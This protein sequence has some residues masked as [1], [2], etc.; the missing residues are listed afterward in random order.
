MDHVDA[1][2]VGQGLAGTALAWQLL[3]RGRSVLVIDREPPVT[4]S[5]IAAGLL[6]P[7]TGKRLAV[8]DRWHE[9]F[10]VAAAFYRAIEAELGVRLFHA[11]PCVRLFAY[12]IELKQYAKGQAEFAGLAGEP[13]PP[14]NSD[15]FHAPRGGFQ[16]PT[17]ARLDT[18]TYLDAS[19]DHF[20][21]RGT[22]FRFD[23]DPLTDIVPSSDAVTIPKLGVS[24]S[25]LVFCQGFTGTANPYFQDAAFEAAKGEI[26]TLRVPGLGETRVM[27]RGVWLA[28]DG[29]EVYRCGATYSW[30]PLDCEPTAAGR[31]EILSRLTSYLKLPVEVIEHSAA[32]RPILADR[33]PAVRWNP[34]HPRVG[35]F[36]GLG[37]KGSLLAP[38]F[39]AACA[40]ECG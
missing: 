16:M 7:V 8:S 30:D 23:L 10:P 14:I 21:R 5:R 4:S 37:S 38:H 36:N 25:T 3:R 31:D 6:T 2:I 15:W 13:D 29:P 17:A 27:N 18:A 33:H 34:A 40:A 1:L 39:A 12:E 28:P 32:V 26:L 22:Y 35:F 19:R 11:V 9:L 24:A 20:R